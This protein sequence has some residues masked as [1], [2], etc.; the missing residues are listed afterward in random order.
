MRQGIVE[1]FLAD[2]ITVRE[3]SNVN[4]MAPNSSDKAICHHNLRTKTKVSGV[5]RTMKPTTHAGDWWAIHLEAAVSA[6]NAVLKPAKPHVAKHIRDSAKANNPDD[7]KIGKANFY[8]LR[9]ESWP[10]R[11][12]VIPDEGQYG[13]H[14]VPLPEEDILPCTVTQKRCLWVNVE[15]INTVR[16]KMEGAAT[17][18]AFEIEGIMVDG[19]NGPYDFLAD[20]CTGQWLGYATLYQHLFGKF[21][22]FN[23]DDNKMDM[24]A[25]AADLELNG[26]P[27]LE[28]CI[29]MHHPDRLLEF[30]GH[31]G[32][33]DTA[34]LHAYPWCYRNN[35]WKMLVPDENLFGPGSD[36]NPED[37]YNAFRNDDAFA[38]SPPRQSQE[39]AQS[40]P[41]SRALRT[42]NTDASQESAQRH[43]GVL[44]PRT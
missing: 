1:S 40:S 28:E 36:Y 44:K 42:N 21:A 16:D 27:S 29:A 19:P 7:I 15:L 20:V 38:M 30:F 4:L 24:S 13:M 12:S 22:G 2:L 35:P 34:N 31:Y 10:I 5:V 8:D 9:V 3:N 37:V 6:V 39:S 17:A 33:L 25:T 11:K 32:L 14:D 23:E 43:Y 26:G 41:G 18:A